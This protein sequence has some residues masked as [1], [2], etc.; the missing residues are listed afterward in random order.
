MAT[1]NCE[2]ETI[3][4]ETTYFHV[5]HIPW[6]TVTLCQDAAKEILP[7]E[8]QEALLARW[9]RESY[10]ITP[11]DSKVEIWSS[12]IAPDFA[13]LPYPDRGNPSTDLA[14]LAKFF[15]WVRGYLPSPFFQSD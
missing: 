12:L 9:R 13:N 6:E 3:D 14:H 1:H 8:G 15:N 10:L 5:D 4:K 11:K 7:L 2:K